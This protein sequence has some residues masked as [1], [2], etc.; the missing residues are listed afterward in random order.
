MGEIWLL[1]LCEVLIRQIVQDAVCTFMPFNVLEGLDSPF[2][3]PDSRAMK[4]SSLFDYGFQPCPYIAANHPLTSELVNQYIER[5]T[6]LAGKK[7][8]PID[9]IV[10]IFDSLGLFQKTAGVPDIIIKMDWLLSL[11]TKLTKPLF[12]I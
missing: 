12:A 5:L 3:F 10:M 1:A 9:G 2:L 8:L 4:I 6:D 11:K 7:H